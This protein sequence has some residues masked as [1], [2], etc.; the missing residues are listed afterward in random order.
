MDFVKLQVPASG[1][2]ITIVEKALMIPNHPIIPFIKGD[3]I[4]PDI[5]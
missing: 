2:K 3:G 4:G 5:W 1:E